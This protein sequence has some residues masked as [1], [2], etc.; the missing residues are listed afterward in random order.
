MTERASRELGESRP[1][2]RPRFRLSVISTFP[3]RAA[4]GEPQITAN[5]AAGRGTSIVLCGTLTMSASEWDEFV[6]VLKAGLQ[7]RFDLEEQRGG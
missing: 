2:D 7:E 1:E 4:D 5:F 3:P 6:R